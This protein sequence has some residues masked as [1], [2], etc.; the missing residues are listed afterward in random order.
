MKPG[1]FLPDVDLVSWA[2]FAVMSEA[3]ENE[4]DRIKNP[5]TKSAGK[6]A[7]MRFDMRQS[8]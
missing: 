2:E 1:D 3:V 5:P 6:P 4:V 7:P 8:A